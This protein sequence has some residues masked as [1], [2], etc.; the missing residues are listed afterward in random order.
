[1]REWDDERMRRWEDER[2]GRCGEAMSEIVMEISNSKAFSNITWGQTC[3][4]L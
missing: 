1:M 3:L 4:L 2:M